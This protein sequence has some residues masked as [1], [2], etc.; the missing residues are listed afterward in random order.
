MH[1]CVQFLCFL[2]IFAELD[3][4]LELLC[5]NNQT[6]SPAWQILSYCLY[7]NSFTSFILVFWLLGTG[8]HTHCY[9]QTGVIIANEDECTGESYGLA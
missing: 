8:I 5:G 1:A 6:E 4:G 2:N 3:I 9:S 7:N